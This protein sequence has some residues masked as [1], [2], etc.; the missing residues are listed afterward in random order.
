MPPVSVI[1]RT[2]N[3]EQNLRRCLESVAWVDDIHVVDA[4]ST[5]RTVEIAREC[6]AEVHHNP[7]AG[8]G[9]QLEVA[10]KTARREWVVALDADEELSPELAA[11][12]QEAI[13]TAEASVEAFRMPRKCRYLGR[14]IRHG[15]WY[16]DRHIRVFRRAKGR[17]VGSEPHCG[18]SVDGPVLELNGDILHYSFA[19]VADHVARMNDYSSLMAREQFR[20]G[21]RFSLSE[22]AW[23]IV[24]RGF[25]NYV[26][27]RGYRDGVHGVIITVV[28]MHYV[29]MQYA[30][31]FELQAHT[32]R[33]PE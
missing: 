23:A 6:G 14:W 22:A 5:D 20:A 8:H 4:G 12:I 7:W 10:L 32:T 27:L 15:E 18:F 21:K 29:F 26:V 33:A 19:G 9:P 13:R 2:L 1:V 24:K 30:K 17:V 25:R 3:E 28:L 16:P 11:Q 31:V